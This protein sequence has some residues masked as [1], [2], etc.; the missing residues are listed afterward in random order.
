MSET[1][2]DT[3]YKENSE[4]LDF[5]E[6]Q[7]QLS[8]FSDAD[9]KLKKFL[10]MSAA[11][12]FEREIQDIIEK[13]VS[14]VSNDNAKIK[15]FVK[16]K[17]IERKYHEYF[18]WSPKNTNANKFLNL[19]GKDFH[20]NFECMTKENNKLEDSISAFIELG[21]LRNELAHENFAEHHIEKTGKEVYSLYR[22]ALKFVEKFKE[23]LLKN[24]S[25][26][27]IS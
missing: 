11:S 14:N 6:L 15:A 8:F 9:N 17:A 26:Q 16:N 24:E 4:L 1:L 18:D 12:Y 25:P 13:F 3:L 2:I 19:F 7:K 23:E 10:I 27:R 5:L 20:R 22:D 21:R